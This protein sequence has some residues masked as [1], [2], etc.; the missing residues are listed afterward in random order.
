M[1]RISEIYQSKQGEGI[2]TGTPSVFV[3]VSGC[4]LRCSFCDTPFASWNPEGEVKSTNE[5]V[6]KILEFDTEHVVITGGEP[7]IFKDMEKLCTSIKDAAR[8]ITIETAGTVF[9]DLHSDL[10][11]ISPKMSNSTPTKESAGEWSIRHEQ[12]RRQ[13]ETVQKLLHHYNHQ[14]KFVINDRSDLTEIETFLGEIKGWT[15]ERILLMPQG[16]NV[17]DLDR[18]GEW[19][20]EYCCQRGFIFCDR[21]HI[22]WYG[23]R[24]GT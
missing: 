9:K 13:P 16:V 22:R 8:H 7:M 6:A 3:R 19:L 1:I 24:R 11:S 12:T 23:N 17:E 5:I 10:M 18:I 15:P 4:N 20:P 14:L 2:L 21:M